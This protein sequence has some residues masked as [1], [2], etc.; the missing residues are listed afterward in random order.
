MASYRRVHTFLEYFFCFLSLSI[1]VYN[2]YA[3]FNLT[4][5]ISYRKDL[6]KG[7]FLS[8]RTGAWRISISDWWA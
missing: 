1:L 4:P 5:Y 8:Y 2:S 3:R 6:R 7:L